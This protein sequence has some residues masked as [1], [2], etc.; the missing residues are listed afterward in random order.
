[1]SSDP[2]PS[3]AE[4][5]V[6]KGAKGAIFLT[7]LTFVKKNLG[8]LRNIILARLLAPED[9]GLLA[10]ALVLIYGMESMTAVGVD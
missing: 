3:G 2:H 10:I 9:F 4:Q 1:M 8:V 6:K 7:A 5:S